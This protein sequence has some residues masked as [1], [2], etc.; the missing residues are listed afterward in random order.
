MMQDIGTGPMYSIYHYYYMIS[1]AQK[2]RAERI[3]T[4]LYLLSVY[5]LKPSQKSE[6]ASLCCTAKI[7][8][9][10]VSYKLT[11]IAT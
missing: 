5:P 11:L 3:L 4:W 1:P 9:K 8:I 2:L 7:L 6:G 10:S